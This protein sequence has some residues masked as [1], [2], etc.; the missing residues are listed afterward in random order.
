MSLAAS[1]LAPSKDSDLEDRSLLQI[2]LSSKSQ[3][4]KPLAA[5]GALK[6]R[7]QEKLCLL[8][9]LFTRY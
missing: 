4:A 6:R 1:R 7:F 5:G 8:G 3:K 9:K 2:V